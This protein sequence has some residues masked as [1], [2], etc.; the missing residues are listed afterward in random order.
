MGTG[1]NNCEMIALA[2]TNTYQATMYE[3]SM[4]ADRVEK[5][6]YSSA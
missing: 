5:H 4:E 1:V 6:A 2:S 3:A